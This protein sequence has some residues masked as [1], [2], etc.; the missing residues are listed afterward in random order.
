MKI[1]IDTIP[2]LSP[3]TG[4]GNYTYQIARNLKRLGPL[5]EYVYF[6]GYYSQH[7]ISPGENSKIFYRLKE[8]VR[9]IPFGP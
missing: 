4:V 3:L 8:A 1:A 7:L 2:L 9:K 5:H 6:Y